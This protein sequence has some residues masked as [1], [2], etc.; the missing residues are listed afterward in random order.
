MWVLWQSDGA[1]QSPDLHNAC[2]SYFPAVALV[3]VHASRHDRHEWSPLFLLPR[4]GGEEV[5]VIPG[6]SAARSLESIITAGSVFA[7]C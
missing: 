7:R 5:L 3:E 1:N 4:F 2:I 6:P